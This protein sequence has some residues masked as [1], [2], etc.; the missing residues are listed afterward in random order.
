M[1][2]KLQLASFAAF[3]LATAFP[4]FGQPASTTSQEAPI[5]VTRRLPP[6]PDLLMRTV[7]IGDLDLK[8]P[9]GQQEMEK[10]VTKAVEDMCAIPSP[11][12]GQE[13]NMTRPCRDEA[14]VGARAQMD[15]AV[16]R[17]SGS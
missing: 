14:W 9:A 13:R 10:R 4:A 1:I 7:Y 16:K 5:V 2:S 15:L 3:S 11:I 12:P 17:A 8:S 6:S